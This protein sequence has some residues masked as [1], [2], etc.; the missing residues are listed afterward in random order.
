M[1]CSSLVSKRAAEDG[2]WARL[3]I[4]FPCSSSAYEPRN[5]CGNQVEKG[6]DLVLYICRILSIGLLQFFDVGFTEALLGTPPLHLL[7]GN[8]P[9]HLLVGNLSFAFTCEFSLVPHWKTVFINHS[10]ATN[11]TSPFV[12]LL[13]TCMLRKRCHLAAVLMLLTTV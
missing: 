1:V 2:A 9:L 11:I 3:A 6:K 5:S 8:P 10:F 4:Y 7:V 13:Q 12:L